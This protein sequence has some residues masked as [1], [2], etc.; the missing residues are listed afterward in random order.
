MASTDKPSPVEGFKEASQYLR[1]Q[2]PEEL[3]DGKDVFGKGSLQL[4]KHHGT[5]QQ[6]D[7][8]QRTAARAAGKGK[9]YMFMVRSRI[10]GGKLTSDQLLAQLQLCD[11]LGNNTLRIT[12]RQGLQLHGIVKSDLAATIAR[13]N[14]SQLTTL[15]ACGDVNRNVMCCPAPYKDAIHAEMQALADTITDQ[16]APRTKAYHEIWL[17]HGDTKELVGGGVPDADVEPIYGSITCPENLRSVSRCLTTIASTSTR[18]T[19]ACWPCRMASGSPVI[20]CSSG[21]DLE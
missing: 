13:I 2:I 11:E 17:K 4:L 15:G 12:T 9:A 1:G 7:R 8:D 20:T 16:L 18:T 14:Q 10:P 5:Y 19:S 3:V 21:V 6:D